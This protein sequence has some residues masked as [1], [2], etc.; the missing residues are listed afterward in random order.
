MRALFESPAA[1]VLLLLVIVLFGAK[2]LPDAAK[3][4]GKSI[5]VFKSEMDT[6]KSNDSEAG[7]IDTNKS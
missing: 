7:S 3:S 6:E 2:R 4:V 1:L 5:K